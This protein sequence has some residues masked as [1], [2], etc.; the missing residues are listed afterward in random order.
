MNGG[1]IALRKYEDNL[2]TCGTGV[3]ILGAWSVLKAILQIVFSFNSIFADYL[4]KEGDNKAFPAIAITVVAVFLFCLV[5]FLL[6]F[7]I[8]R[9]ASKAAKGLPYKKGYYVWAVIL[10]VLSVIS[11]VAYI[12]EFSDLRNIDTTI[13]SIIVDITLIYVLFGVVSST[14]KI[15]A[16]R[17]E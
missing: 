13:A 4:G 7:Y 2:H 5:L 6:H 9:N 8:G 14:R 16:L 10:L 12:P 3:I 17:T 1:S 11:M 15:R